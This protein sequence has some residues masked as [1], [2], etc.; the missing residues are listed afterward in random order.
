[1]RDG[2]SAAVQADRSPQ[3]PATAGPARSPVYRWYVLTVL[4]IALVFNFADRQIPAI[5][6]DSIK[7]DLGLNDS[8][9]GLLSGVAFTL[10]YVTMGL[11]I[12]R[13][14]DR[15]HRV[16]ILSTCVGLWSVMTALC[17]VASSFFWLFL[18][19]VG[20]GVGEA[21][22]SPPSHSLL[23]DYFARHERATAL[24]IFSLGMPIGTVLG[25]W[26]G[27]ALDLHFGWRSAFLLLGL[28][29]ILLALLIRTTVRE[30]PRGI[31]DE[32]AGGARESE[33]GLW[34]TARHL[35]GIGSYRH[36]LIA[37]SLHTASGIGI[38]MWLPSFLRRSFELSPL[39][40]GRML[41][42]LIG[43][44]ASL[45]TVLGGRFCDRLGEDDRKW[46]VA[47]PALVLLAAWP[48]TLA[49]Y[50]AETAYTAVAL[51]ILP[52]FAAYFH[53]GSILSLAQ[54]LVPAEMR[55]QSAAILMFCNGAI[56]L[57]L[58]PLAIGVLSDLLRPRFGTESLRYALAL[59]SLVVFWAAAHYFIAGRTLS[60]DLRERFGKR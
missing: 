55:T 1:M 49:A 17:A 5:L 32:D 50:F 15:G 33:A 20:V 53:M 45:G 6:Q 58:M 25:F 22:G 3:A 56:A 26:A 16:K 51:M 35:V 47:A 14:A 39:E 59:S 23:S 46:Y 34:Q 36:V 40:A 18:A 9:L 7:A 44:F 29:G 38:T 31:L 43:V 24:G 8:Q 48:F 10:F 42:L 11:W 54:S 19:R 13:L 52:I 30:P 41:A 2:G 12:A 28:P 60:A 57:G 37:S 27:G 4:M 21:G